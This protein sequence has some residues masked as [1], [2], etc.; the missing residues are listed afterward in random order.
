MPVGAR[1]QGVPIILWMILSSISFAT[2]TVGTMDCPSQFRG[3]VKEII[4]SLEPMNAF[5]T[6]KVV[7]SNR[8]TIKGEV[9]DQV[10]IEVLE[11]GPFKIQP[12]EEYEVKLRRGKLCWMEKI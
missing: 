4:D 6:Q 1:E 2:V 7:F 3:E 12:G 10:I 8:E 11:N 5:S 9:A